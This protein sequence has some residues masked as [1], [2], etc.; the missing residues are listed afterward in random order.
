MGCMTEYDTHQCGVCPQCGAE[1]SGIPKDAS[2][3]KPGT[4]L[5]QGR[6]IAGL[7][8]DSGKYNIRIF[9]KRILFPSKK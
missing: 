7:S 4:Q 1:N 3:L 5:K 6:Y 9:P 8:I 2:H